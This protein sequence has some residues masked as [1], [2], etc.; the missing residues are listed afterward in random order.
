[1]RILIVEDEE[2]IAGFIRRGLEE[3]G[4]VVDV[5][6]DGKGGLARAQNAEYD[7]IVLDRMLPRLDG[8]EVLRRLRAGGDGVPVLILTARDAVDD[9]VEGLDAGADD[10]LTKPFSFEEFLARIRALL[11]RPVAARHGPHGGYPALAAGDLSLDLVS[12][13]ATRAGRIIE[14]SAREFALLEY[15][16]RKVGAVLSRTRIHQHV[17]DYAYDGLSNVVDV[18]VNALR[19]KLE[20]GGE[21]RMILTVRGQGYVLRPPGEN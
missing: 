2:R 17:W 9:K 20:A 14:L 15:F 1:M 7:L 16:L 13:Q 19:K 18:Y 6:T 8:L 4:Y 10:Y 21:P 5:A 3:E 11:R 12:R